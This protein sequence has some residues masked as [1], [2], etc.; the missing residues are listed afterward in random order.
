LSPLLDT[1]MAD[2]VGHDRQP[3]AFLVYLYLWGQTDGA[4]RVSDAISLRVL[5]E[6]TGLSKR[7]V[8][9]AIGT[10]EK[11]RLVVVHRTHPL[12]VPGYEVLRPWRR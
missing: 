3:S 6:S 5:A 7:A 1:L 9:E 10:L 4:R 11:R 2:L 8:Q 12:A